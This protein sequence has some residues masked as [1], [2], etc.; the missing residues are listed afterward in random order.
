MALLDLANVQVASPRGSKSQARSFFAGLLGL[1]E[2]PKPVELQARG[3]CWFVVGS[4]QL[5]LGIEEPFRPAMK[6]HPALTVDDAHA[7]Y[8]RLTAADVTCEWDT[9]LPNVVRFY[10]ADPWGN[11]IEFV[12]SP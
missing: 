7:L 1:V 5:H 2:I 8:E 3:G 9:A 12:Q 4:R 11:R 6:A 10:A